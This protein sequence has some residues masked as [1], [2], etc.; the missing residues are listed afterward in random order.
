MDR[1]NNQIED[2]NGR[3]GIIVEDRGHGVF[4]RPTG[5]D[6]VIRDNTGITGVSGA[7][8]TTATY[9]SGVG[10]TLRGLWWD[11]SCNSFVCA[12]IKNG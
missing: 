1:I 10:N 8:I 4:A 12:M 5:I 6:P 3:I 7:S 11:S 9:W 2:T